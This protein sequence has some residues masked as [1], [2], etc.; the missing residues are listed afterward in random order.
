MSKPNPVEP[1]KLVF[2]IFAKETSLLNETIKIL[3]SEYGQ[4]DFVSEEMLFR[5]YELLQSLK[6]ERILC[7]AFCP[8]KN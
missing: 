8:W 3:S 6:W 5:L 1:V 2:S 4:P 7:G